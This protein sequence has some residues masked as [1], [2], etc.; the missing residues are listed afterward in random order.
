MNA[1]TSSLLLP[2]LLTSVITLAGAFQ[3]PFKP[4]PHPQPSLRLTS[5]PDSDSFT[6]LGNVGFLILAGGT[7]SRMKANVPKQFL[8]LRSAPVLH[9]SLD[10][11]LQKLPAYCEQQGLSPPAQVVMVLD[12]KYQQEYQPIVDKFEGK[13]AFADPGEERQGS[14]ESGL[15][16][17]VE[18]ASCEFIA[19]H[20]SAR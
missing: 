12:P 15:K 14:V 2:L 3:T 11:F 6:G 19:V 13:L 20:D 8:E 5:S 18:L 4:T 16:K 10:L 17:L 7:G 1:I 9:Y